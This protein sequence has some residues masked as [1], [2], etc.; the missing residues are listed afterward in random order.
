MSQWYVIIDS[1]TG[2]DLSWGTVLP[3]TLPAG[4]EALAVA[5]QPNFGTQRWNASVRALEAHTPP[6]P[7]CVQCQA[8]N[9]FQAEPAVSGLTKAQPFDGVLAAASVRFHTDTSHTAGSRG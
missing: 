4:T 1:V 7:P 3:E 5:G 9:A 2:L 6:A 8:Y